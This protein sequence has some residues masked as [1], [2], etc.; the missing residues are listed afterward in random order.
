MLSILVNAYACAPFKG[1][2][3]G[4]G[5]NWIINMAKSC[6]LYIIT[7][8]EWK[9]DIEKIMKTLPERENI[10]FYYNPISE[11]IRKM[12]WNQGDWR[13]YYYYAKWQKEAY[14]IALDIM[15]HNKIDIIHQLNMVGFRE[16]GY[17]WKIKDRPFVWGPI[18]GIGS[19][20]VS[21]LK[22]ADFKFRIFF[23]LKNFISALQL[24]FSKRVVS[25][26]RNASTVIVATPEAKKAVYAYHGIKAIQI[27]ETGCAIRTE[28][29][30]RPI[31]DE[32]HILWVGRFI[33]TK[34][35]KLALKVIATLKHLKKIR[36][37][38]VGKAFNQKDTDK[39]KAY[40]SAT[41]IDELCI[42]H[43]EIPHHEVLSLMKQCDVFFFT[44]IFE[45][46]STVILEAIENQLPIVCFNTCG[47]GEIVD[48]SIG[49]KI[50]LSDP[51]RSVLEFSEALRDMY[52]NRG[53]LSCYS[54]NCI[55]KMRE[56]SWDA[57][58]ERLQL[59]YREALENE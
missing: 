1:S 7:E 49:R 32:F 19:I 45:A 14:H 42:W 57:K 12:C 29:I 24:R 56:C 9:N 59:I 55:E 4:M 25:A 35:L 47:F 36:F 34:Q 27:N 51:S 50:E 28:E 40:A 8:G 3:P 39:Y 16:P 2:E 10:S 31:V 26:L 44:S 38:I 13:F 54:R 20:P 48:D 17:L 23:A 53:Q 21:Y 52:E 33:Y 22:E 37:H 43:G 15:E 11:K 46:T 58:M 18:A 41:G 5:W 30:R 6:K